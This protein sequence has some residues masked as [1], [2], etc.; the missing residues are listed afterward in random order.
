MPDGAWTDD[1]THAGTVYRTSG[2]SW[3]L[4]SF[5]ASSVH[6]TAVGSYRLR[7]ESKDAAQMEINVDGRGVSVAIARQAF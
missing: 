3:T 5:D 1:R 6:A 2:P 7:F 4:P